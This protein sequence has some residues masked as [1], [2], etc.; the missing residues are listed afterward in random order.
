MWIFRLVSIGFTLGAIEH[1][2]G[3]VGMAFGWH[4]YANY[5][6]WR[7][8]AFTCVDGGIA[9][10]AIRRP[11]RVVIPLGAMLIEQIATN[12]VYAYDA[13]TREHRIEWPVWIVLPLIA[14]AFAVVAKKTMCVEAV[15][16]QM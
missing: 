7:H 13:L 9:W 6:W 15:E 14:M 8:A 12:G 1:A 3:L 11:A 10:L 5:P 16:T 4:M 2:V